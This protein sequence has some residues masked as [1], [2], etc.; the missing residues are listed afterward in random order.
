MIGLP[1][2]ETSDLMETVELIKRID[3]HLTICTIYRPYPGTELFDYCVDK[4]LLVMKMPLKRS[5]IYEG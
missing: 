3:P 4:G 2:E 5:G 1:T